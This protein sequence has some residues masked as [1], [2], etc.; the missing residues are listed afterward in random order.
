MQPC[1]HRFTSAATCCQE[2]QGIGASRNLQGI[3]QA[4]AYTRSDAGLTV[5]LVEESAGDR[6]IGTK[7]R[8]QDK[9]AERLSRT[10]PLLMH[11]GPAPW[12]PMPT[13]VRRGLKLGPGGGGKEEGRDEGGSTSPAQTHCKLESR[14][15]SPCTLLSFRPK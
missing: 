2:S 15:T 13:P 12:P 7:R 8:G 14:L 6:A 3:E 9:Y 1:C 10:W 5:G 4:A 11:H